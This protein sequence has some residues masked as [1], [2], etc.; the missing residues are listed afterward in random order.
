[1]AIQFIS[2]V[3]AIPLLGLT[4]GLR[5]L[6]PFAV[7]CWFAHFGYLSVDGTWAAWTAYPI[8][9]AI[10]T[11]A[12]VGEL[13]YDKLPFASSRT[14][15]GPFLSRLILGGL[16]GS[17]AATAMRGPG[18]EGVLLGVAGAAVG[19]FAG[20][21]IRKDLVQSLACADW[22]VALAEDGVT[23]LGAIL[24]TRVVAS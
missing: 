17:L 7:F 19:T 2:W 4:T 12:A 3:M 23:I 21:M 22:I 11:L 24:A 5:A 8:T 20:Y 15:P 10:S 14:A 6:T 9:V 13:I 1:M 16:M 18:L